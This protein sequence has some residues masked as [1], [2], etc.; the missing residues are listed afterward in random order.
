MTNTTDIATRRLRLE[1]LI[2]TDETRGVRGDLARVRAYQ[3]HAD[4]VHA[5][6]Q[7]CEKNYQ[8]VCAQTTREVAT[9]EAALASYRAALAAL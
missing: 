9:L 5:A 1:R 8:A 4:R 7:V 3:A 2:G 6:G